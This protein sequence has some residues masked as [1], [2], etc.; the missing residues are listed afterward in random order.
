MAKKDYLKEAREG[1][2]RWLNWTIKLLCL[3]WVLDLLK[4]LPDAI[5]KRIMDKLLGMLGI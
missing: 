1:F 4:Y 3:W 2:D 5:A